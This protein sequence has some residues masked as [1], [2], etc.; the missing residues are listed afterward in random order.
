MRWWI[1]V[2]LVFRYDRLYTHKQSQG[3][4]VCLWS[5]DKSGDFL[6]ASDRKLWTHKLRRYFWGLFFVMMAL[7]FF[8]MWSDWH[9]K[10]F[11]DK[12]TWMKQKGV[13]RTVLQECGWTC[14]PDPPASSTSSLWSAGCQ[15]ELLV[16]RLCTK[17]P[18]IVGL[19]HRASI[20]SL[21]SC[22]CHTFVQLPV[23][24]PRL[25]GAQMFPVLWFVRCL[26]C[27]F[28]SVDGLI[29]R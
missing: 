11:E 29:G 16:L 15:D 1:S 9:Q 13:D 23:W 27:W 8:F 14:W 22:F 7:G 21:S 12:W 28:F 26:S 5:C 10:V 6:M 18:Q 24:L 3:L 4:L 19:Q 25:E 17:Q 20:L 2:C